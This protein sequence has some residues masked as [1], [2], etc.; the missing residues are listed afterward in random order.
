MLAV[1]KVLPSRYM[2]CKE[3][4]VA[5]IESTGQPIKDMVKDV[6]E[7]DTQLV[8]WLIQE[9]AKLFGL[10]YGNSAGMG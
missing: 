6:A 7:L 2:L 5:N 4:L 1:C 10:V 8:A 3:M 9:Q